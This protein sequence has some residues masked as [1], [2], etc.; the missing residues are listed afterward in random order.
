MEWNSLNSWRSI[1]MVNTQSTPNIHCN[2]WSSNTLALP[3]WWE[4]ST[5]WKRPWCW[6]GLK[7]KEKGET[8]D[9]M[10]RYYHQLNGHES[11]Q[12]L[13]DNE[14]QGRLVCCSPPGSSVHGILQARILEWV[15][16]PFSRA[17]SQPRKWTQVS[18][19]AGRFFTVWA[20]R[21]AQ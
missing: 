6:E 21:E 10:V 4:E 9:E 20:T 19:I 18:H 11:E 2:C 1:I 8:K 14:G 17:S 16:V 15:A 7:Q 3:T 13:G 12:T 5:Y